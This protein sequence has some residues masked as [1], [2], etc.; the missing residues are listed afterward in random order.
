M[1]RGR[2]V[3]HGHFY[4][5]SRADPFTGLVPREPAAAPHHDWNE[6]IVAECYR[7]NAERGNLDHISSDLGPTLAAWVKAADEPTYR[8]FIRADRPGLTGAGPAERARNS[9][10]GHGNVMAQAFH[11]T[12]LPLASL[13]DRRTEIRWGIHDFEI[14]YGRRPEGMWLPETAVDLSTLR[15]LAEHDIRYTILAP[16]Q[17]ADPSLDTRRLYRVEVGGGRSVGV[18]FYD[19]G[20]SAAVSFDPSATADADAFIHDRLIPRF[21]MHAEEPEAI[22]HGRAVVRSSAR[23][24][25]GSRKADAHPEASP[26]VVIASDG[27]L[28]G[29]HREFREL[30]L[31]RLVVG[32]DGEPAGA[33]HDRGFDVVM[34]AQAFADAGPGGLPTT[35]I[36][37]RTS[38]SCHHGVA[39]W[40]TECPDAA[41]G[42]WKGPLRAA[43]ERLAARVDVVTQDVLHRGARSV[44]VSAARDAYV[45][46]VG[47]ALNREEYAARWLGQRRRTAATDRFLDLMEGQRWRLAMF[48]SDAWYWDDPVRFETKQVLR[49][50]ARAVR[51]VDGVA[52]TRLED[53]LCEDLTLFT[54]PSRGLDG[55]AIYREALAEANQPA[56]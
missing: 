15:L 47:D 17:A 37:E 28:Y 27:E 36:A 38:W 39:R 46:V 40:S 48:Q 9:V 25:A 20:L 3:V 5:P 41:D 29:H 32:P 6:R 56:P 2:L 22:R 1:T 35:R 4:Q 12:I 43:L 8:A 16:W 23:G 33:P 49:A 51:L 45:E 50:A 14:R 31:H 10:A 34:L 18:A 24:G 13:A 44:D 7:P 26:I 53:A 30:F 55:L 52:G 54:S 19:G 21:G 11:H 42:R